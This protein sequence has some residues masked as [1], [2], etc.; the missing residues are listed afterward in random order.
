LAL[1]HVLRA[2]AGYFAYFVIASAAVWE[3]FNLLP[4]LL[5]GYVLVALPAFLARSATVL[6]L[7]AGAA[8]L[9]LVFRLADHSE[10]GTRRHGRASSATPELDPFEEDH[11]V[12]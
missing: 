6:C 4:T 10:A 9:P 12:D 8:L 11:D 7:G 5:H 2:R 1:L 3:G